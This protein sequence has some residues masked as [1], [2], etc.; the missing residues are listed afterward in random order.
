[1]NICY[2]ADMDGKLKYGGG[3]A[4]NSEAR[5]CSSGIRLR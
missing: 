1:M 4:V 2:I 3:G 5:T